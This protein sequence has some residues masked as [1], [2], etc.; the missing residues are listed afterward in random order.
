VK[1]IDSKIPRDV[2]DDEMNA[3]DEF[4]H[5][6]R[7]L[8]SEDSRMLRIWSHKQILKNRVVTKH[9]DFIV[10]LLQIPGKLIFLSA[11]A[12]GAIKSFIGKRMEGHGL[13]C[14]DLVLPM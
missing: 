12:D 3:G 1:L 5:K 6:L 10:K 11:S 2:Q 9:N 13:T 7:L 14:R 4:M 8:T